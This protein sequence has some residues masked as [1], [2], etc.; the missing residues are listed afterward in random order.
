MIDAEACPSVE[1]ALPLADYPLQSEP[2]ALIGYVEAADQ[3]QAIRTAIREFAVTN[4]SA[5]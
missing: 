3:E 5:D 2:T 4:A 1:K